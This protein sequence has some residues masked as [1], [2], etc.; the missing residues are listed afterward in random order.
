M[1]VV[2]YEIHFEVEQELYELDLRLVAECGWALVM[3]ESAEVAVIDT[4]VAVLSGTLRRK[5]QERERF[6]VKNKRE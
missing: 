2:R 3:K 6:V 4:E 1:A 5:S